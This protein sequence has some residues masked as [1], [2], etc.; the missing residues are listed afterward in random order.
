MPGNEF[1]NF[2]DFHFYQSLSMEG[3]TFDQLRYEKRFVIRLLNHWNH[4]L[5]SILSLFQIYLIMMHFDINDAHDDCK[6]FWSRN[7]FPHRGRSKSLIWA[8]VNYKVF[9]EL[10]RVFWWLVLTWRLALSKPQ[11]VFYAT[12]SK[13][14]QRMSS[15]SSR[16]TRC[17]YS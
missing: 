2:T 14:Y 13:H 9:V 16:S 15:V 7:V 8:K 3:V 11:I 1:N 10:S 17:S 5:L 12:S 6:V 4:T